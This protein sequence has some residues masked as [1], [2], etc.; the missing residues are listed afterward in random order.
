MSFSLTTEIV[1]LCEMKQVFL[2]ANFKT[3]SKQQ[4]VILYHFYEGSAPPI[5]LDGNRRPL[6][7]IFVVCT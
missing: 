7:S 3:L 1:S 4:Q 2:N 6:K 5:G